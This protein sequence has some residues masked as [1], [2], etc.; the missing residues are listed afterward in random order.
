[1]KAHCLFTLAALACLSVP[2]LAAGGFVFNPV[3]GTG[4]F[5]LIPNG[6]FENRLSGWGPTGGLG[7]FGHASSEA[8]L[9]TYSARGQPASAFCGAGFALVSDAVALNQGTTYVLSAFILTENMSKGALYL[10]IAQNPAHD[11]APPAGN[12]V[13]FVIG[14]TF[15]GKDWAF[16]WQEITPPTSGNF[17]VRIVYDGGQKYDPGCI[18]V[19]DTVNPSNDVF[20]DGVA[21]TPKASFLKP[22]GTPPTGW[23][24]LFNGLAGTNGKVPQLVGAGD[25]TAGAPVTLTLSEALGG[26]TTALFGAS[27]AINVPF[28]GGVLVPSAN[29][30]VVRLPTGSGCLVFSG[31]WPAGVPNGTSL[32]FQCWMIDPGGPNGFSAS[33]GLAATV[34]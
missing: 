1:M 25:L 8:Y 30:L 23:V 5:N 20:I 22:D 13:P 17:N 6:S 11:W 14:S 9:G 18:S 27:L 24:Y 16:V 29:Q 21:I 12:F 3:S 10:D 28:K 4:A 19:C 34:P 26:T 7:N 33:N 31:A 15:Y 32:Y 2:G